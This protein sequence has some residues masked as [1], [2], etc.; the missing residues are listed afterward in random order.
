MAHQVPWNKVILEEFIKEAMLSE[1]EEQIMRTRVAG[2]TRQK[3]AIKFNM[4]IQKVDKIIARCKAKY[5]IVSEYDA[6]LPPRKFSSN[7]VYN[8]DK[9]KTFVKQK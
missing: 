3:Q 2:W 4:S 7:D 9:V 6:L 1:E 5:D 8:Y